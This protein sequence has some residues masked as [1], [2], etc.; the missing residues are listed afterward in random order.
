M[1][2]AVCLGNGH[3][4]IFGS[5]L[6]FQVTFPNCFDYFPC[7]VWYLQKIFTTVELQQFWHTLFTS[8]LPPLSFSHPFSWFSNLPVEPLFIFF[9]FPS[10]DLCFSPSR[11]QSMLAPTAERSAWV[12]TSWLTVPTFAK[13]TNRWS[14]A[15]TALGARHT[16]QSS[17]LAAIHR[18]RKKNN[19]RPTV[20]FRSLS[21][22]VTA[23]AR[24]VGEK[25]HRRRRPVDDEASGGRCVARGPSRRSARAAYARVWHL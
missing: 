16:R 8:S 9:S 15:N 1:S 19:A 17:R 21:Q 6:I 2:L 3:F 13:S 18:A 25:R 4:S 22:Q 14:T 12:T 23:K 24:P 7:S 5:F 20:L 11:C 10:F